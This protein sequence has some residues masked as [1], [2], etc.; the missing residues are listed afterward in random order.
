MAMNRRD[1]LFLS[2]LGSIGLFHQQA[3]D[4]SQRIA[5]GVMSNAYAQQMGGG[6][7][8]SL[9]AEGAMPNWMFNLCLYPDGQNIPSTYRI[10]GIGTGFD[11][12]GNTVFN[13]E[14]R[15]E[16]WFPRLWFTPIPVWNGTSVSATW[17]SPQTVLDSMLT[18]RG[19]WN[20]SDGHQLSRRV[21][22][23]PL[24]ANTSL[25]GVVADYSNSPVAGIVAG[26]SLIQKE[27]AS[28]KS[29]NPVYNGT[30]GGIVNNVRDS[31]KQQ[32][33]LFRSNASLDSLVTKALNDFESSSKLKNSSSGYNRKK[34][35]ELVR[36]NLANIVTEYNASKAKYTAL[37]NSACRFDPGDSKTLIPDLLDNPITSYSSVLWNPDNPAD[38]SRSLAPSRDLRE[39][40]STAPSLGA[41]ADSFAMAEVMFKNNLSSNIISRIGGININSDIILNTATGLPLSGNIS[42]W[43]YDNGHSMGL[44]IQTLIWSVYTRGLI[45]CLYEFI[46]FLKNNNMFDSTVITF[47]SDFARSPQFSGRGSDHGWQ[48]NATSIWSGKIKEP[49]IVGDT[50]L[51]ATPVTNSTYKN[52]W[53][54]GRKS[55]LLGN[56][57]GLG[58][59]NTTVADILGIPSNT[60]NNLSVIKIDNSGKVVTNNKAKTT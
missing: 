33:N 1:F 53:G 36:A 21:M 27:F 60:T 22:Y 40:F 48:A 20:P 26:D 13:Q 3:I 46:S 58:N 37:I 9:F 18:I 34:A 43:S 49:T 29:I 15:G 8:F 14:K 10:P 38:I 50:M 31:F 17:V 11:T 52:L 42:S 5:S 4:V 25:H 55:D 32:V 24:G 23:K 56:Y 45:T 19:M 30:P 51:D 12:S 35:E 59:M 2:S 28:S 54:V 44:N 7:I 39:L 41:V 47:S 6:R 57:I 16:Y